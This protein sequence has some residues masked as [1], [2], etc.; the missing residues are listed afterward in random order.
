MILGFCGYSNSGKTTMIEKIVEAMKERYSIAVV[1]HVS[2]VDVEGKDSYR[3]RKAGAREVVLLGEEMVSFK[4]SAPLFSV[5]KSLKYDIVLV[6]GFKSEKFIKKICFGDAKCE[7][8]IMANPNIED[9][10]GYIERE[11]EIEHIL[12]K[13]PNFNC[14]EC[15]H[16]NCEEMARAIYKG[17]DDFKNCRY[18]NPNANISVQ[19]NGKEIYMGKFAQDVVVNTISGL[20]SSFKG[21]KKPKDI[22]IKIEMK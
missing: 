13:L 21:V 3:F 6:E 5:L 18:W 20:L 4:D 9:V 11:V 7:N 1:K 14:G 12:N 16:R 15:G 19:V 2:H 22:L 8:C 10:I 17:E